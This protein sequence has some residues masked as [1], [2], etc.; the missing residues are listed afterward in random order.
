MHEPEDFGG[1]VPSPLTIQNISSNII[2]CWSSP[3]L[4]FTRLCFPHPYS[5]RQ[6]LKKS[7]LYSIKAISVQLFSIYSLLCLPHYSLFFFSLSKWFFRLGSSLPRVRCGVHE[8]QVG[9]RRNSRSSVDPRF[10]YP[11]CRQMAASLSSKKTSHKHFPD[12]IISNP[13]PKRCNHGT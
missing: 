4:L 3:P 11:A 5:F 13:I 2:L 9:L 7:D 8:G 12:I 10:E 6:G 1:L